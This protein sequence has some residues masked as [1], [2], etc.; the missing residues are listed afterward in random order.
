[1]KNLKINF[2]FIILS[3]LFFAQIPEWEWLIKSTGSDY[4]GSRC[5]SIDNNGYIYT[6]GNYSTSIFSF[7]TSNLTNSS[8]NSARDSYISKHSSLGETIW[9]KGISG[10]NNEEIL[11][12]KIDTNNNIYVLGAFNSPNLTI[13]TITLANIGYYDIYL[14]K[15]NSN[16]DLNWIKS[17]SGSDDDSANGLA[18]D[19]SGNIYVGGRFNSNSITIGTTVLTNP[20]TGGAAFLLKLDAFGNPIWNKILNGSGHDYIEAVDVD[21]SGNIF[22]TGGFY[23]TSLNFGTTSISN[24]NN[25][26]D[27]FIAKY[28]STGNFQWVKKIGGTNDEDVR[29]IKLDNNGNIYIT[30]HFSSPNLNLGTTNLTLN[31]FQDIFLTKYDTNGNVL[32]ARKGGV[33]GYNTSTGLTID[34]NNNSYISGAYFNSINFGNLPEMFSQGNQDVFLTKFDTNGNAIWSKTNGGVNNDFGFAVTCNTLNELFLTGTIGPQCMPF[35]DINANL[36][37]ASNFISK[38]NTIP[39]YSNTFTNTTLAIYPNPVTDKINIQDNMNL[40]Q[41]KYLIFDVS[42]KI[43]DKYNF[44]TET[45]EIDVKNLQNG[46]YFLKVEDF[47]SVKFIKN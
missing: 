4:V 40:N 47:D 15:F 37:T 14:A 23:S 30:G 6:V 46:L 13:G 12:I 11:N 17:I 41:K 25:Y 33:S 28:N 2:I 34:S 9:L 32:W 45:Y 29:N 7:G 1:M 20:T 36:N 3:N 35:D 24:T 42:G 19:S 27:A 26:K 16:G 18:L 8:S 43:M 38:L 21:S 22:I 39:L 44:K 5:I 31:S 10:V